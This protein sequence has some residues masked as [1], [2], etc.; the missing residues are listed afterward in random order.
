MSKSRTKNKTIVVS[1][2]LRCHQYNDGSFEIFF[3]GSPG[4][5]YFV[6]S[7]ECRLLYKVYRCAYG[8]GKPNFNEA[9][10]WHDL[11]ESLKREHERTPLPS[12]L[13]RF[14][15]WQYGATSKTRKVSA[16]YKKED[17]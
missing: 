15:Q 10:N 16:D 1:G 6:F 5:Y 13:K 7:E 2:R 3:R 9:S 4:G 8:R 17:F 14:L 11:K 12:Y